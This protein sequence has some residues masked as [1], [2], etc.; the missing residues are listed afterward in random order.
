MQTDPS[1]HRGKKFGITLTNSPSELGD[2][3]TRMLGPL[4]KIRVPV[5]DLALI[6]FIA[7][8]FIPILY[9]EFTAIKNA[10]IIRGVN[11]A[12]SLVSRIRKPPAS[13]SRF[14][15]RP[16]SVPMSSL[17]PLKPG[18]IPAGSPGPFTLEAV[19]E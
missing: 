10:Q 19:L 11:F 16:S 12:G 13:L 2:A 15:S 6:L 1:T 18:A 9:E 17:W 14:L 7:L 4:Q 3:M 5:Y 8:R